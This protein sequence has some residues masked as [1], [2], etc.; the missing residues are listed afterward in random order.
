[1]NHD[2]RAADTAAGQV[3]AKTE[4]RRPVRPHWKALTIAVG[5]TGETL[6]DSRAV[7]HQDRRRQHFA[8][9]AASGGAVAS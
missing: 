8:V 6:T 5:R 9:E 4:D 3:V 7:A 1:M 2:A